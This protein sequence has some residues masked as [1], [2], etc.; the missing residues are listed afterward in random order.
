MLSGRYVEADPLQA[1]REIARREARVVGEDEELGFA[2]LEAG[3]EAVRAR[4]D[5][6]APDQDAVHVN[7]I[8]LWRFHRHHPSSSKYASSNCV[9]A[10][11][12]SRCVRS[13]ECDAS[14][15]GPSSPMR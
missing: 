14:T 12:P 13:K 6:A 2:R 8:V 10:S 7:E 4:D 15:P 9:D 3:Q 11:S 5:R 1:V